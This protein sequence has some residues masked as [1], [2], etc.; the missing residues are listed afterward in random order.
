MIVLCPACGI[1][2][3]MNIGVAATNTIIVIRA[4]KTG[5]LIFKFV[6]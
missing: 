3:M 5:F 6:A 4:S 2:P 1:L